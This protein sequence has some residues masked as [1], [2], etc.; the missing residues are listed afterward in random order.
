MNIKDYKAIAAS[1]NSN[2]KRS[3]YNAV[4]SV[5]DGITFDSKL[6]AKRYSDLKILQRLGEIS[7]LRLQVPYPII[8]NEVSICKYIAD[9]VYIKN[10][11]EIVE[12]AKGVRTKEYMLKKKLM[13]AIHNITIFEHNAKEAKK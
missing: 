3:K 10:G 12:D 4:K 13:L 7:N 11:I 6:E 5:V 8:V 9:F 2:K 1:E